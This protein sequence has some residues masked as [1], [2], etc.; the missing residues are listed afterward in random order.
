VLIIIGRTLASGVFGR[1]FGLGVLDF[2]RQRPALVAQSERHFLDGKIDTIL[3]RIMIMTL[4]YM[5]DGV[6][7]TLHHRMELISPS[8]YYSCANVTAVKYHCFGSFGM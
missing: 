6:S 2:R 4:F 5:V 7:G 8:I 3:V 1:A